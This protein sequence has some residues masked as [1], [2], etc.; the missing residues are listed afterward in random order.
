MPTPNTG[1][2]SALRMNHEQWR[3]E[4]ENE[5]VA[6][7]EVAACEIRQL[8]VIHFFSGLSLYGVPYLYLFFF[9]SMGLTAAGAINGDTTPSR[10]SMLSDCILLGGL[11]EA[12]T[13]P[14]L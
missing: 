7:E 12:P 3:C 13:L 10:L 4:L 11:L 1:I 14:C 8:Y 9:C 6:T 2:S 5:G